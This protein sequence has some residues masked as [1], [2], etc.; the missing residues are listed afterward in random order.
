V[1]E[2]KKIASSIQLDRT[3]SGAMRI[4][5]EAI[6]DFIVIYK[7]EFDEEISQDAAHAIASRLINLYEALSKGSGRD[8]VALTNLDQPLHQPIGFRK[9]C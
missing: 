6:D 9:W 1:P 8:S 7:Q 2:T 3:Y 4:S 5:D